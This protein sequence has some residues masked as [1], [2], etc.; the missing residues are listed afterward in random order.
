VG[1]V[2]DRSRTGR[3]RLLIVITLAEVGGA[4]SYVASLL[5]ALRDDFDVLVAAYGDGPLRTAARAAGVRFVPLRHVR[6]PLSPSEDLRGFLELLRLL[7]RERPAVLHA[8]SSKAG[9]LGRLAATVAGVPVRVFTVHGWAFRA[10]SGAAALLYLWADRLLAPVTAMTICVAQSDLDAG[11]RART[12]RPGRATVIRNG[13]ALDAPATR[14][15]GGGPL[16]VVSVARL[17]AP[18]DVLTLVRAVALLPPG[19]VRALVVGDGPERSELSA[20]IGRLGLDGAVDLAGERDDVA[21]LLAAADVFVLPSRSE[22]LPMSVL[23]A[24]AAGLPVVA[25]AVGGVPELV[26]DGETGILVPPGRPDAL[27]A[28]LGGLAADPALRARL[29]A[30]GR[31]RAEARFGIEACRRAHVQL[32]RELLEAR[33]EPAVRAPRPVAATAG[34]RRPEGVV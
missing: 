31:R 27:A 30:A 33:G 14:R 9:I 25:S 22:G 19:G 20:E 13:V 6:R 3:P 28:A 21:E 23:E 11:L 12:C 29:G 8:N 2:H 32:Y 7:R 26:E 1:G 16:R 34:G 18:K 24:M 5:P 4:Q 15:S 10:H 17:R